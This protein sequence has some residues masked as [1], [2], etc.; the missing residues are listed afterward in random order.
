MPSAG[1][2]HFY[3]LEELEVERGYF[4]VSMPSA[5]F[6]HFYSTLSEPA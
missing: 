1:F 4:G 6:F 2:F 3:D 5:G